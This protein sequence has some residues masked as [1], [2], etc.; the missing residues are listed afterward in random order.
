MSLSPSYR[1]LIRRRPATHQLIVFPL[2]HERFA[3]PIRYVYKVIPLGQTYGVC[4]QT[5]ISLTRYQNCDILVI[6]IQ[7][8]I[9][10]DLPESI[11]LLEPVITSSH[12]DSKKQ[13]LMDASEESSSLS[14]ENSQIVQASQRHLLLM[15]TSQKELIGI[16]LDVPPSLRR[17]SESA[18]SPIP[19]VYLEQSR[20]RCISALVALSEQETPVFLLNPGQLLQGQSPLLPN[21]KGE[22]G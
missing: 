21:V 7:R 4:H 5:G 15:Q 19:S 22:E 6:D 3:L 11:P 17:V 16:P 18:F 10:P 8:R 2:R 14:K 1:S 20:I 12:P 13:S 9:F